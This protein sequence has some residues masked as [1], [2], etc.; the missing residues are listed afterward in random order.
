MSSIRVFIE[1]KLKLK[2][3][4]QKTSICRPI[5]FHSL[6]YNFISTY[7]RGGN[8]YRL[9]VSPKRFDQM[10]S[11]VKE[12]TC[13][14]RP[15]SFKQRVY[16]LNSYLIGWIGYFRYA[17]MQGKLKALDYWIRRRLRYCIWKHW[18]KPNKR[19][20]S[21]IRMGVSKGIA[22]SWSRSRMGGWAIAG[23]PIMLTTITLARL[24][25]RGYMEFSEY[26]KRFSIVLNPP[27]KLF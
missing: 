22:Y 11:R 26:Y 19:M 3:N 23:S 8:E 14:T 17:F 18:K 27:L 10:K 25:R 5:T 1:Q 7:K 15:V 6:G 9:R 12:I 24:K 20:R 4:E 2:V 21:Y 13:K 16:E